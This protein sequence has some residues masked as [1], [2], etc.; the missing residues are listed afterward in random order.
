MPQDQC[1]RGRPFS[2]ALRPAPGAC[3]THPS[4][5]P[6]HLLL[7][8]RSILGTVC[9]RCRRRRPARRRVE[10]GRGGRE[11]R[12]ARTGPEGGV[13]GAVAAPCLPARRRPDALPARRFASAGGRDRAPLG[14]HLWCDSQPRQ[15]NFCVSD[16]SWPDRPYPAQEGI[17]FE[18]RGR[19]IRLQKLF[20]VATGGLACF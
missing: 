13:P 1:A 4:I 8:T 2:S 9:V 19:F 7:R 12:P 15:K 16:F 10:R 17:G 14:L 18:V 5:P 20:G 11:R 3:N 6:H